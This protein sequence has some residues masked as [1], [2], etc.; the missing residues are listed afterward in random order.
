MSN[1]SSGTVDS[2]NDRYYNR[3]RSKDLPESMT[4]FGMFGLALK[5]T[6]FSKCFLQRRKQKL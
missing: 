4:I 5:R 1:G 2:T 3:N 6:G